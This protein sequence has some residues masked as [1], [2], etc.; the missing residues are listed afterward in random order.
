MI[1]SIPHFPL[2]LGVTVALPRSMFLPG[3]IGNVQLFFWNEKFCFQIQI[4][5]WFM[6]G[7][8]QGWLKLIFYLHLL[9]SQGRMLINPGFSKLSRVNQ[10]LKIYKLKSFL[11]QKCQRLT[12]SPTVPPSIHLSASSLTPVWKLFS[13]WIFTILSILHLFW[14][15]PHLFDLITLPSIELSL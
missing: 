14:W 5:T 7:W 8:S 4:P 13:L 6:I 15:I 10:S 11:D 9:N 12:W 1:S 3:V 2:L